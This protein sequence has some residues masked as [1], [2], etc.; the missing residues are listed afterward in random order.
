MTATLTKRKA[1]LAE[2]LPWDE[3]NYGIDERWIRFSPYGSKVRPGRSTQA[4]LKTF[5]HSNAFRTFTFALNL[6]A[7][8]DATPP[9]ASIAIP[10]RAEKQVDFNLV[11][12]SSVDP[13]TYVITADV[14]Q[15][16]WNLPQW[17][18]AIIEV[19]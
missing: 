11:V 10:P 3:P 6:P 15:E 14:Q 8:F 18:E 5:N 13:G 4:S 16:Q 19:E 17:T 7:G 2:L 9:T 1:L 12:D